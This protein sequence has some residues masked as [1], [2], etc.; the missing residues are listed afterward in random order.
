MSSGLNLVQFLEKCFGEELKPETLP[1][2]ADISEN[3]AR[4]CFDL[5]ASYLDEHDDFAVPSRKRDRS[6]PFLWHE[7]CEAGRFGGNVFFEGGGSSPGLHA[8][9][10]ALQTLLLLHHEIIICDPFHFLF[11]ALCNGG[12]YQKRYAAFLRFVIRNRELIDAKI[13]IFASDRQCYRLAPVNHA[14]EMRGLAHQEISDYVK[15][16]APDIA[17]LAE[18]QVSR[19]L[20]YI[21]LVDRYDA[22]IFVDHEI[23]ESIVGHMYDYWK[24]AESPR[25]TPF[26]SEISRL[27]P[28][29]EPSELVQIRLQDDVFEAWR[30]S[31]SKAL[32]ASSESE[33]RD[34]VADG[35]TKLKNAKTPHLQGTPMKILLGGAFGAL[36]LAAA[37][38]PGAAAAGAAGSAIGAWI[39][40]KAKKR[41]GAAAVAEQFFKAALEKARLSGVA[42]A[43]SAESDSADGLGRL[44]RLR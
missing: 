40:W 7:F 15:E 22:D 39:D 3:K 8:Q 9:S 36:G 32:C 23:R 17:A 21:D 31:F 19:A 26:H 5:M 42:A 1:K 30:S 35:L 25:R 41:E 33:F 37:S 44:N 27:S 10:D 28:S 34:I 13:L 2:F 14:V 6:R 38:L 16:Q 12:Y 29:V 43:S 24:I 11:S 20:G 18:P 4:E